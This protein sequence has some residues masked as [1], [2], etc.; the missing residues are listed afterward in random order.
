MPD[1]CF[2]RPTLISRLI[3]LPKHACDV[4]E[5]EGGRCDY[6]PLRVCTCNKCPN[7]YLSEFEVYTGKK[8]SDV[9]KNLGANVIKTLTKPYIN[10]YRHVYFDNYFSSL[11]LLIDLRMACMG[12]ERS[13]QTGKDFQTHLRSWPKKVWERE[14]RTKHISVNNSLL[15]CDKTTNQC[16]L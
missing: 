8:G 4:H 6:H 3:A 10:T 15:Q 13:A 12:V 2:Q 16:Q 5:W 11:S 1:Q 7:E 9:Q 14:S